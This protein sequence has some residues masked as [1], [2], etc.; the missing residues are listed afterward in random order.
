MEDIHNNSFTIQHTF[1]K[2][3]SVSCIIAHFPRFAYYPEESTPYEKN[4]ESIRPLRSLVQI[5]GTAFSHPP[6]EDVSFD[7]EE[8]P[9]GRGSSWNGQASL[10]PAGGCPWGK[11]AD[12]IPTGRDLPAG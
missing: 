3:F 10:V 4:A 2:L 7:D 12:K 8:V 11:A 9:P 5:Y 6:L 1:Q